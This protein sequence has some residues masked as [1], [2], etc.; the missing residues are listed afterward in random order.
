MHEMIESP[1]SPSCPNIIVKL[2]QAGN[3]R[4][5]IAVKRSVIRKIKLMTSSFVSSVSGGP[6]V[7]VFEPVRPLR[8]DRA[9]APLVTRPAHARR[10]RPRKQLALSAHG[11]AAVPLLFLREAHAERHAA[12]PGRAQAHGALEF[13]VGTWGQG[14]GGRDGDCLR[15]AKPAR[16]GCDR[17]ECAVDAQGGI[18]RQGPLLMRAG[19]RR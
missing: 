4:R 9:R 1:S 6:G 2:L 14:V 13:A 8:S 15:G 12:L 5:C 19:Q 17:D 3:S 7:H 18:A 16:V 11:G 10:H